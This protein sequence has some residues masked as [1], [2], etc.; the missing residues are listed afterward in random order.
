[1]KDKVRI[2]YSIL[3]Y[4]MLM[5]LFGLIYEQIVFIPNYLIPFKENKSQ[6]FNDFH[7][8]TNPIHYHA[9]PSI[10]AIFCLVI[11]WFNKSISKKIKFTLSFCVFTL[12]AST[13][14]V[15][16]FVNGYL[17]FNKILPENVSFFGLALEWSIVN[18]VRIIVLIIGLKN[19]NRIVKTTANSV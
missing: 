6:L 4:S 8:T 3:H 13:F 5:I 19:M 1:M 12:L 15:I 2:L 7:S 9:L 14:Y 17:F 11:F 10:I 18:F 16:N